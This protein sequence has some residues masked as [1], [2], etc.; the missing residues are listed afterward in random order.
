[1]KGDELLSL[2]KDEMDSLR[3]KAPKLA[4]DIEN[5]AQN[6]NWYVVDEPLEKL[7]FTI[8][9]IP[10]RTD[11]TYRQIDNDFHNNNHCRTWVM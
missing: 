9:K 10:F 2:V 6:I 5:F 3:S 4:E 8:T 11:Q 7:P 1:M